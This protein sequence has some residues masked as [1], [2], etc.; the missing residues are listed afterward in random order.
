MCGAC[1]RS[2]VTDP[3]LGPIRTKRDMLMVAHLVNAVAARLP[4]APVLQVSGDTWALTGATGT[5]L[6]C[7][8][9]EQ[10]WRGLLDCM[11]G[12]DRS[13]ALAV[14]LMLELPAAT[15]LADRVLRNG[16][17]AI[18][19]RSPEHPLLEGCEA[20]A[21]ASAASDRQAPALVR[22]DPVEAASRTPLAR[23]D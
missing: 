3:V 8:T 23:S 16:L 9:V 11:R 13:S 20:P 14:R 15:P 10:V 2:V 7:H 22:L 12:A 18:A 6:S 5:T 17:E 19:S 1:G 21:G 4:G